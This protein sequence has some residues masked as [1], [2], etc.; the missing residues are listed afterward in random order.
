MRVNQFMRD[1]TGQA[2]R[3]TGNQNGGENLVEFHVVHG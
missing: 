1:K 2:G 3:N